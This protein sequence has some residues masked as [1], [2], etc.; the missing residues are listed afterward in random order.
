MAPAAAA[1]RAN[2][3]CFM[4]TCNPVQSRARWLPLQSLQ[5]LPGGLLPEAVATAGL[6]GEGDP[7]LLLDGERS[8]L[9]RA[10]PQRARE[11]AGGR[12]CARRALTCF[13][14]GHVAIGATHDR[15]PQWPAQVTGS[16]THTQGFSAAAVG[17]RRRFRAIGI[18]AE[19][20]GA[21]AQ[22][23]WSQ[24]FLPA[25][26]DWLDGLPSPLQVTTATLMFS[27]KEAFYKC[28]YEITGQWLEF[29]DVAVE[30]TDDN[31][32]QCAAV[33]RPLR[34]SGDRVRSRHRRKSHIDAWRSGEFTI[35]AA[36]DVRFF[37][38]GQ[39]PARGRFART[40]SLVLTAM[41]VLAQPAGQLA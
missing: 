37:Q 25:E 41:T 20:A 18:D 8:L 35:R 7:A 6:E 28:Q 22:E 4:A 17:D 1:G 19:R 30:L 21:A 38:A 12:I 39:A 2:G 23:I 24:V 9:E 11:I 34:V 32:D 5:S 15:R 36:G 14:L 40:G 3:T 29:T 31:P 10:A 26:Q 13:G 16:I 27:A 33:Q